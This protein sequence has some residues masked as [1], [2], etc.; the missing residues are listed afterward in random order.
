M[1]TKKVT[2]ARTIYGAYLQTCQYMNLPFTLVPNTTLNEKFSVALP[3]TLGTGVMPSLGYFGVGNGGHGMV[4]GAGGI[5]APQPLPH[6]ASDASLFNF[7]PLV[8]CNPSADLTTSQQANY[9][10]RTTLTLNGIPYIAYYLKRLTLSGSAATMNLNVV[11]NGVTT[12]TT[13]TPNSGNLNPTPPSLSGGGSSTVSGSYLT[14]SVPLSIDFTADDVAN[15]ENSANLIYGNTDYAIISELALVSGVDKL[16]TVTP[17]SGGSYSFN[18]AIAT[19]VNSIV[20]LF[21]SMP[22]NTNGFN[23]ALDVGATE[24]LFQIS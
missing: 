18:E 6:S 19:Q 14:V 4:T 10:M 7:L 8:L 22:F 2:I 24:A 9:A 11:S 16:I 17:V 12:T 13:F 1:A 23:I 21:E 3:Q 15:L 20:S 5:S